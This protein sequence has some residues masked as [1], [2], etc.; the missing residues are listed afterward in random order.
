[1]KK[2]LYTI[3]ISLITI[4]FSNSLFSADISFTSP[5]LSL[6]DNTGCNATT[7]TFSQL[8]PNNND[9]KINS[10]AAV[11]INFPAGTD[12]STFTGGTFSGSTITGATANSTQITFSAPTNVGKNTTFEIILN[13][14][15]NGNS[16]S[17]NCTISIVNNSSGLDTGTYSFTTTSCACAAISAFPWSEDFDS[18]TTPNMPTCWVIEDNGA[19]SD[20]WMTSTSNSSSS[21]NCMYID[22]DGSNAL[23]DWAF[24]PGFDLTNGVTY[25]IEFYY[26]ARSSSWYESLEFYYGT[27]QSSGGMTT[28]LFDNSSFNHITYQLVSVNITPSSTGT[29]YFGWHAYSAANKYGIHVD[30]ITVDLGPTCPDPT[31]L[32]AG[33]ITDTQ[34]V[35]S[36]TESGSATIWDIELGASGFSPTG[37]PTVD[38]TT[39]N[40]YT[41]TGLTASTTY[42]Y[43]VRSDCGGSDYS[44][45]IGPFEFTTACGVIST[46]PYTEDFEN[47]GTIPDCWTQDASNTED[48][49]FGTSAG[50][51]ASSDHT[52]GSGYFAWIDDSSP[53]DADPS[54]LLSPIFNTTSLTTPYL[55]FYYWIGSSTTGSSLDVDVYNGSTWQNS[56]ATYTSNNG[57][58]IV[59]IDLSSYSNSALQIRFSVTENSA[60]YDCDISIDDFVLMEAPTCPDPSSLAAGSI[61]GSQADLSWTENGSATS[62]DIELGTSGF[63]PTGTPT[64]TGVTNPYTY[65]G[66]N[67]TTDYE[68]YVHSDCGGSDYSSWVGPYEFTTACGTVTPTYIE[69]FTD[70][71][72][73]CW[74]ETLGTLSAP[75]TLSGTSSDWISDGFANSGSTGSAKLN[76]YSTDKE[77]W[78]ISP[79]I[80]LGDGSIHYQ[81]EFDLAL[82]DYGSTSTAEQTGT[83]DRFA[84]V[85]STDNGSTWTSANTL[86]LWDNASSPNVYNDISNTGDHITINLTSY[87]G[88][89]QIG[90]YGEST[91]SNADN[92]LFVDNFKVIEI[93]SCPDPSDLTAGSILDTQASLSW[94]ENG[95]ATSWDIELGLTG[96]SPT[97]TPT[98]SSVTNPYTYTGLT[99][100]TTYEYYVRAFC[101]GS[102]YSSWVGPYEFTTACAIYTIPYSQNMESATVPGLPNCTSIEND[103]SGNDWDT[104]NNP[105]NGFTSNTLVYEYSYSYAADAWFYTGAIQMYTGTTYRISFLYGTHSTSYIEKLKV[106]YGTSNTSASM[107]TNLLDY[108]SISG[109][110]PQYAYYDFTVPSDGVYYFGF[111]CYSSANQLDLYVD[112]ILIEVAPS[113]SA[114]ISLTA[115][116]IIYNQA[117]L[118][119]TEIGSATQW[120]IE[121]GLTGFSPTGT[122]TQSS[123]TNPYSY[124]GLTAETTYQYYVRADCGG[125][126]Y[127][128][129]SGPYEFSTI[130]EGIGGTISVGSGET[131]ETLTCTGG[132]F[133]K[134]N[135]CGLTSNLTVNI[136]SDLTE[137]GTNAL[138]EWAGSYTLTI[139]PSAATVRDISGNVSDEMIRINGADNITIDGNFSGS[140]EYFHFENTNS[141][142]AVFEILDDAGN[143]TIQNSAIEGGSYGVYFYYCDDGTNTINNC[144]IYDFDDYGLYPYYSDDPIVISNN[145][146]YQT[147]SKS[148]TTYGI[149]LYY[150]DDC[151]VEK[152]HIY[153]LETTS[154]GYYSVYGIYSYYSN[155]IIRNNMLALSPSNNYYA[156]GIY[157]SGSTSYTNDIYFNSVYIGGT[158]TSSY[159]SYGVYKASS[160]SAYNFKNNI[161]YNDRTGSTSNQYAVYFSSSTGISSENNQIYASNS[162]YGYVGYWISTACQTLSE[163]QIASSQDAYS[164][165]IEPT[166]ASSTDLHISAGTGMVGS[167]ITGI[168]DD[169]DG[170]ARTSPAIG[171]DEI[172]IPPCS[173]T[174]NAG[175][176][177]ISRSTGC[178]GVD[179]TRTVSG[180]SVEPGVSYQ[181]QSSADGSTG[182]TDI[183]GETSPNYT[184]SITTTTY[185]RLVST[186]SYSTL[187]NNSNVVSYT[188]TGDACSC[189]DYYDCYSNYYTSDEDIGNVTVGSLDNT[190]TLGELAGG[191]GSEA[192]IYSNYTGIVSAP[193][194]QQLDN[195]SFSLTSIIASGSYSN[196]FQIYIDYD[197]DGTFDSDEQAYSSAS[198]TSGPHTET[199][200]FIIPLTAQTGI[201]R[202]RVICMEASFP[203]STNYA[204]TSPYDYGEAEDYCVNIT[205]APDCSG[206][207][208]AGTA[209]ISS[210]TG[211]SDISFDLS[212]TGVT[213][214]TG[215]SY[216]WQS[217]ANGTSGWADISGA[218]S[219]NY[220]TSAS[221]TT[222]Y[223]LVTTCSLSSQSNISN[224]VSYTVTG[225]TCICSEYS[226]NYSNYYTSY[227]DIGNVTVG[228]L[229]NTSTLGELAGGDN[230]EAYIYSNYAGIVSAPD[231]QQLASISFSLTSIISSGSYANGFQIYIDYDQDGTFDSDERA[232]SSTSSTSGAHTETGSFTIPI[233]AE[234]GITR[235]R[236]I[237][238][239]AT[240]PT[241]T[242]YAETSPYDYGETE[243]YCVNITPAPDCS[244]TPNAGT[245]SI[246]LTTGCASTYHTVTATGV[247]AATGITYQWQYSL[248]GST[249]WTNIPDENELEYSTSADVTTYYRLVTT[250]S[251]SGL[252]NQTNVVSYTVTEED[253]CVSTLYLYDDGGDGWDGGYVTVSVGGVEIGDYDLNSGS[254]PEIVYITT[255]EDEAI[256][257]TYTDG[258]DY[259]ENY[260]DLIGP[261]GTYYAEDW[262]PTETGY[263]D[264]PWNGR[265][266]PIPQP[267][268]MCEMSIAFCTGTNYSFPTGVDNP[269]APEGP[270]YGCLYTQPNPVYY[271][272]RVDQPGDMEIL[273][274]SD[275][276]DVD[277]AAWG[278]FDATTCDPADLTA[279]GNPGTG[280][281]YDQPY[282]N[283]VD[284][285]YSTASTETLEIPGATAG[286]Y[287]MIMINN[288]A[289]CDGI[290]SFEQ[291]SGEGSSD[292]TI[293][294]PPVSNDGPYCVGQD[295]TLTVNYPVTGATYSWT[296]PNSFTSTEMNPTITNAGPDDSG[297][298]SLIITV[299]GVD[300]D[301]E[302]TDV[303]VSNPTPLTTVSTGDYVF[304]NIG[305]DW[306]TASNWLECTAEDEYAVSSVVPTS[307]D[308]VIICAGT[309]CASNEAIITTADAT[310]NNLTIETACILTMQGSHNL[311]VHSNWT[312]N[313]TYDPGTG[314]VTFNGTST[315][316]GTTTSHEFYNITINATKTMT[317]PS[318]NINLYGN[319]LNNGIFNHNSGTITLL[320]T[321]DQNITSGNYPFY[322]LTVQNS[323]TGVNLLDNATVAYALSL[324]D[325][326]F[327]TG[328]NY[329]ISQDLTINAITNFSDQSFVYGNI[330]KY[331]GNGV[332]YPLPIGKG[333]S[334]TDYLR[335]DLISAIT[336]GTSYIDVSVDAITET[337][338][339]KD[340]KLTSTQNR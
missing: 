39:N 250:C 175:T 244:G 340:S 3:L 213:G 177:A 48:W 73:D 169:I 144:T 205:P 38:G 40:P 101:G 259:D 162:T 284:C 337:S 19:A 224:V 330:R 201:T 190:S 288:Y 261:E 120:D 251:N 85:I 297:T 208:N 248:D 46:F 161:V 58:I 54:G 266:C 168:T 218:T 127:S 150:S 193:D 182:W 167:L 315:I 91:V 87:T 310:C 96:F 25:T 200:S 265:G 189:G 119:W 134:I 17:D 43:Y 302:T 245:A 171:A 220:S 28:E 88:V 274:E 5:S 136:T 18:E 197:Q 158:S 110:T 238:M 131:Y 128:S 231:L 255:D 86:M 63:S 296:G 308:N 235:M 275:C 16:L 107:T 292:C 82:T 299:D 191:D 210:S 69:D 21:P 52:S 176:A 295:I 138:N 212:A 203:T 53:Y 64:Q 211:C 335:A 149:R 140:G 298:Y 104:E 272:L 291:V 122:P 116:N 230:S 133:E 4:G 10:G 228:T 206:T 12:A 338:N 249:G 286:E 306:N 318:D 321:S 123:V 24:S 124:A 89:V 276:G 13:G 187:T 195:I 268:D 262:Y 130:C 9:Y 307:A 328:S 202:M 229:D 125:G 98:Q 65:T 334:S 225:N 60:D 329:I 32:A 6:T 234:T 331:I 154:G 22:Y 194:L 102:D 103:G 278:P 99:A 114:P 31:S 317:A 240:F 106:N 223:Q 172:A 332:T 301:P 115:D 45:W 66:L 164:F 336:G 141:S 118:S 153:D 181:W 132:L 199:G 95:S 271:Y 290:I 252:S 14:I 51:A 204:E 185:Y 247:T 109:T 323:S 94:T 198:S 226:E 282:G 165:E 97:G 324:V 57:W 188:V 137:D 41:Y 285:A 147:S 67:A 61:T 76:I 214:A 68:Y 186:C 47:A 241:S 29:Y 246:D 217:S 93:P 79:S 157:Y 215:I 27:S 232:Y 279:A 121:L 219:V 216:Q 37:T 258:T 264:G 294:A 311:T 309:T 253:C 44:S 327:S 77:D 242:N 325:G 111:N 15:T 7:Y 75:S 159:S 166:F 35:L 142:Y 289:N 20:D 143:N 222:Y 74:S 26:R 184:T 160:A 305:T 263:N 126:D 180:L 70:Y 237:C 42:E 236:I 270:E 50:Y 36:W 59:G 273:I 277:F 178:L 8:V 105:G 71:L 179:F 92:D 239:E 173:G 33:S 112:D 320:G 84:V 316:S 155:A 314:T 146:I 56:I 192:Y 72:P 11:T 281:N 183:T 113:C 269:P 227:E 267:G 319:W 156:Y 100:A 145:E 78:L 243:D 34:A 148:N 233:S 108:N 254:G 256:E 196:G 333:T 135:E 221:T 312:N 300:S 30:D 62:W 83:D 174:P 322:N 313:G 303:V 257:I 151:T 304:R 207:P 163:F 129:W 23:D 117:D 260:F 139:Q 209:S 293:V 55:E 280:G 170:D 326:I 49:L 152:N 80:D 81:L 339:N 90:F 283:L 2:A 287:Y 1:M